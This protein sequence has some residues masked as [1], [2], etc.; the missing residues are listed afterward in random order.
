MGAGFMREILASHAD[1]S[2]PQNHGPRTRDLGRKYLAHRREVSPAVTPS[3]I[4]LQAIAML[5]VTDRV[6][7]E[8]K[9]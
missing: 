6:T 1:R 8:T 2:R 4:L 7:S 3:F 5:L 9:K